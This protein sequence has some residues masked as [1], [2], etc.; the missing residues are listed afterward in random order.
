MTDL[1]TSRWWRAPAVTLVAAALVAAAVTGGL[2]APTVAGAGPATGSEP[3][4]KVAGHVLVDGAGQTVR[5]LGVD[6][7][8]TEYACVDGYAY[9]SE[10]RTAA[11]ADAIAS[12]HADAVRVPLNEDCWLGINGMP[13]YGTAAGYRSAVVAW[14]DDLRRAGLYVV[15]DLHWSAPGALVADGQRPMP[16]AHSTAFWTSV[17]H[18]FR[19]DDG[20][21]FDAFNEPYSPAADGDS[22]D[23]VSWSCWRNGGCR[24]P[25]AADGTAVDP[26]QTYTAVGMQALVDAIRSAGA[27]QPILL[28]GLSYANDLSG[29]LAHEPTDP[30]HQLVA[31]FHNYTGERCDDAT[32]WNDTIAP[33]AAHVPVVTGEMGEGYDCTGHASVAPFDTT[34]MNWADRHGVGYLAWQWLVLASPTPSCASLPDDGAEQYSVISSYAGRAL[35]PDGTALHTRL[36]RLAAG[37]GAAARGAGDPAG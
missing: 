3:S 4:I 2:V 32:C 1:P 18:T 35:G 27:D 29:W 16:D 24:V 10:P 33:L 19:S 6:A 37:A 36:G 34:Y 12:W 14:V 20:V 30:D 31:S 22:T 11:D 13:A 15:V 7:S 21:L 25:D 23:A 28:G 17:A 5:L 26:S 9:S 8:S